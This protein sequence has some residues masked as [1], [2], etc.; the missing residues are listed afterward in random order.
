MIYFT[1]VFL[2]KTAANRTYHCFRLTWKSYSF[3]KIVRMYTF[4]ARSLI[5]ETLPRKV[6]LSQVEL[7]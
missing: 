3:E 2:E 4:K 5:T 6:A 7:T 1:A